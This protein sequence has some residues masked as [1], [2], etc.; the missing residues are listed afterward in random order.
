MTTET[1]E[2]KDD[3]LYSM[4]DEAS[5]EAPELS[6]DPYADTPL[7][8]EGSHLF[9]IARQGKAEVRFTVETPDPKNEGK[10]MNSQLGV[11]KLVEYCEKNSLDLKAFASKLPNEVQVN[12]VLQC[13][14]PDA[15][16]HGSISYARVSSKPRGLEN[17]GQL[18]YIL[19]RLGV[20]IPAGCKMSNREIMEK[21]ESALPEGKVSEV[22]IEREIGVEWF[23]SY[24]NAKTGKRVWLRG[25]K[26]WPVWS[27]SEEIPPPRPGMH[28]VEFSPS[29]G[30]GS[31]CKASLTI[32]KF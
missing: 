23:G 9:R 22:G 32:K 1:T 17:I 24:D 31:S 5:I 11:E 28:H 13:I 16:W 20:D 8:P 2:N 29:D 21:A 12:L 10:T 18:L 25:M 14:A 15:P 19:R 26:K 7:P 4:L 27:D 6:A 30:D 3:I